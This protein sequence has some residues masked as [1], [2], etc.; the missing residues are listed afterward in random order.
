MPLFIFYGVYMQVCKIEEFSAS[1]CKVIFEDGSFIV[2]YKKEIRKYGFAEGNEVSNKQLDVLHEEILPYR[3]KMRCMKLLQSRDYTE[4]EI[5]KK[6]QGDSYPQA[7]IDK[8][9][10]CLKSYNYIND[11]RYVELYYRSKVLRKSKKQIIIDLQ[12]KGISKDV[13]S[14]ILDEANDDFQNKGDIQCIFHLLYKRKYKDCDADLK[15]K[16]R[17]KA[18]LFRKGFELD[19]INKCME[20]FN[21]ENM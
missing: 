15:E 19:D 12:R 2:V 5:K 11:L 8:T 16:Q 6:L 9:I 21:W 20:L 14:G 13:I 1:K 17:T 4:C 18:Y 10:E 3:A 7:V